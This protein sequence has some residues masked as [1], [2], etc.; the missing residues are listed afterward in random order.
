VHLRFKI[1]LQRPTKA[2]KFEPQMHAEHADA[3]ERD[4][5]PRRLWPNRKAMIAVPE[6][7]LASVYLR[8]TLGK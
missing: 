2:R 1:F 3:T 6:L 5:A 7:V 8:V 4:C